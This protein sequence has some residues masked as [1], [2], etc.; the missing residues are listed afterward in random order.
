MEVETIEIKID[1]K[2]HSLY[3]TSQ[4]PDDAAAAAAY[5]SHEICPVSGATF[6][7]ITRKRTSYSLEESEYRPACYRASKLR[8]PLTSLT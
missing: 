3:F 7:F 2:L 1:Q 5:A 6:R 4:F 8:I